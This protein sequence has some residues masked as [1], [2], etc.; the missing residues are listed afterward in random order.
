MSKAEEILAIWKQDAVID[1]TQPAHALLDIPKLHSKYLN[2]LT[3]HRMRL[4]SLNIEM[5]K[6]RKKKWAYYSGK[7]SEEELKTNGWEPFPFVLKTDIITYL[8]GDNDIT[9]MQSRK[10]INEE[11]VEICIS[12]MKELQSRTWQ[13]RSYIDYEKFLHGGNL[14]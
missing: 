11:V 1:N 5:S 4:R 3:T 9:N 10:A 14:A 8:D 12:I 13:L 2:I 6:L 7:M